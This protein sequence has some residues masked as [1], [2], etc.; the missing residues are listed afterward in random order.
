VTLPNYKRKKEFYGGYQAKYMFM[1]K[2]RNH[3][4]DPTV[5]YFNAAGSL[6]NVDLEEDLEVQA[7]EQQQENDEESEE[8]EEQLLYNYT[9]IMSDYNKKY[10]YL[11]YLFIYKCIRKNAN[12][13]GSIFFLWCR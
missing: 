8:D 1:K 10:N 3:E 2:C 12:R 13:T 7:E 9:N 6:Y 11:I 5:E 4:L